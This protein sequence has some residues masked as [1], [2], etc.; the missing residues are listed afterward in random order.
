MVWMR[1]ARRG[2]GDEE[3]EEEDE[4]GEG[5][6]KWE[7]DQTRAGKEGEEGIWPST[8]DSQPAFLS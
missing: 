4:G 7:E 1:S 8:T 5:E 6:I 3:R 2:E